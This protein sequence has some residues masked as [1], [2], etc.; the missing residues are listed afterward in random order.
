MPLPQPLKDHGCR[1]FFMKFDGDIG[2]GLID[3]E[4]LFQVVNAMHEIFMLDDP[5]ACING[6]VYILD[7][8]QITLNMA[9][10]FTPS[11]LRKIVQFYEKSLP[12]RIK[13]VHLI[14]TPGFF[15]GV[16]SILL[17]LLTEKLRKRVSGK[18]NVRFE[19]NIWAR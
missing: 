10:K 1:I 11:F 14:N 6:I 3:I 13:S 4:D 9:A 16:L 12:L 17:P 8:K 19:F 5:Y 15:H 18:K 7:L 2:K